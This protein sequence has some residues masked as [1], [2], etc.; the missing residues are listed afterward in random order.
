MK[1]VIVFALAGLGC[2]L[3]IIFLVSNEKMGPA[4][5]E[6]PLPIIFSGRIFAG[7]EIKPGTFTIWKDFGEISHW[8]S[9][10]I[11]SFNLE[12][13]GIVFS[14]WNPDITPGIFEYSEKKIL[15][16]FGKGILF[17]CGKV[18]RIGNILKIY[19]AFSTI[20][21]LILFI[22]GIILCFLSF[23]SNIKE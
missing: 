3:L 12:E 18:E 14:A 5:I 17:S 19:P 13:D 4:P 21:F 20:V 10:S 1:R 2:F 15:V 22:S 7:Q 11:L 23:V 8:G 6:I 9:K 16:S